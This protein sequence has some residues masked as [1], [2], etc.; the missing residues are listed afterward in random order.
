[1]ADWRR[2]LADAAK[3]WPSSFLAHLSAEKWQLQGANEDVC[4]E[5][6]FCA[7]RIIREMSL[8][9]EASNPRD[10]LL[11]RLK[12]AG[13]HVSTSK[14]LR[15]H[16]LGSTSGWSTE[17]TASISPLRDAL[18]QYLNHPSGEPPRRNSKKDAAVENSGQ[19]AA[20]SKNRE[21]TTRLGISRGFCGWQI[22]RHRFTRAGH[23]IPL[24][25]RQLNSC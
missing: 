15:R 14:R 9:L 22:A 11:H 17:T 21:I 20:S 18:I 16:H 8:P 3:K 2:E 13:R 19:N 5:F 4:R 1:M 23:S 10:M 6:G 25:V 12:Q 7:E 24:C